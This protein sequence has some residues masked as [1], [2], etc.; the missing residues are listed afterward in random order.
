MFLYFDASH[1]FSS[2]PNFLGVRAFTEHVQHYTARDV[3]VSDVR[4]RLRL[5]MAPRNLNSYYDFGPDGTGQEAGPARVTYRA[6]TF[7]SG[8]GVG[9]G[10]KDLRRYAR[11]PTAL[12]GGRKKSGS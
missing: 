4:R 9:A 10:S 12:G 5:Q 11:S 1:R 2:Q 7:V 3:Y 8:T 6:R